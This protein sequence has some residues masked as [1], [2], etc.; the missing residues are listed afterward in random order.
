MGRV[1]VETERDLLDERRLRGRAGPPPVAYLAPRRAGRCRAASSRRRFGERHRR[2]AGEGAQRC[3]SASCGAARETGSTGGVLTRAFG[4]LPPRIAEGSWVDIAR[5]GERRAGGRGGAC[6]GR[7]NGEGGCCVA[8]S[9]LGNRSCRGMTRPGSKGTARARRRQ[10]PR[11][12]RS[13]RCFLRSGMGGGGAMGGAGDRADAVSRKRIPTLDGSPRRLR[14]SRRGAPRVRAVPAAA[15]RR[16]RS[17]PV[18]ET[19]SIYRALLEAPAPTRAA[20]SHAPAPAVIGRLEEERLGALEDRI[21]ADLA[22]GRHAALVGELE[23]LVASIRCT[24]ASR[25]S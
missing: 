9:L 10:R 8:E 13:G 4:V 20:R 1:A 22:L 11:A 15:R 2:R 7:R 25:P 21:D 16:A 14:R 6:R 3:S 18:P 5:R 12:E 23:G 19:E 24:S 17:V